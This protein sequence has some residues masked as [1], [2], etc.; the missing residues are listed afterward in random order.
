MRNRRQRSVSAARATPVKTISAKNTGAAA[1]AAPARKRF[2]SRANAASSFF[3]QSF[4]GWQGTPLGA[5]RPV[6]K[7]LPRLT[8]MDRAGP[9]KILLRALLP[10]LANGTGVLFRK[11]SSVVFL[12]QAVLFLRIIDLRLGSR[13]PAWARPPHP[14]A[15]AQ[16]RFGGATLVVRSARPGRE[17]EFAICRPL[18]PLILRHRLSRWRS[19]GFV[20]Q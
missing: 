17:P 2:T 11:M 18:E 13:G 12:V 6:S 7:G 9:A 16:G 8:G 10:P 4:Y 20:G 5:G 3:G 1:T 14:I 19:E 15:A